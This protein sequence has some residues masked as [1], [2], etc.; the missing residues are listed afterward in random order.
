MDVG[1]G[2]AVPI[3]DGVYQF[4]EQALYR[5]ENKFDLTAYDGNLNNGDYFTFKIPAP[6]KVKDSTFPF[7][8]GS[9]KVEVGT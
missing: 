9:T 2:R 3:K 1:N 6:L 4:V 8:D 5:F 7:V